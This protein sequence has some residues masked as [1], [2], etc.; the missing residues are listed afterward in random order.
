MKNEK[1]MDSDRHDDH[2]GNYVKND[3]VLE[4]SVYNSMTVEGCGIMISS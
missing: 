2:L 3:D 4:D 1:S